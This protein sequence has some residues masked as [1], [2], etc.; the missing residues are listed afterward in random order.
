MWP[1]PGVPLRS[2]GNETQFSVEKRLFDDL[3]LTPLLA[4]EIIDA[5]RK[6]LGFFAEIL[7]G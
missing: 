1:S 4:I 5:A 7:I 6:P 3:K 2:E